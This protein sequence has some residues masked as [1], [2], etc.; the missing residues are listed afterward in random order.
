M[1]LATVAA[2]VLALAGCVSFQYPSC[3]AEKVRRDGSVC[4][5][6]VDETGPFARCRSNIT[7]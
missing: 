3:G 1:M 5:E 2:V 7:P 6:C 4:A